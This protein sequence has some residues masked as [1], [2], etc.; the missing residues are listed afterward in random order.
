MKQY[1]REH[2]GHKFYLDTTTKPVQAVNRFSPAILLIG[3]LCGLLFFAG[4]LALLLID[5]ATIA[6]DADAISFSAVPK[7][8]AILSTTMFAYVLLVLGAGLSLTTLSLD[9]RY[10]VISYDG[11]KISVRDCPFIGKAYSF[12]EKLSNFS[13]VRLRLKFCQYGLFNKNKFIIELYHK[14]PHKIVPLYISTSQKNIRHLWR[15]YALELAL[16]PIHISDKGMVSHNVYDM[17]RP[18]V[19]VVKSWHLPQNFLSGKTHSQN[20]I[21]KQRQDK[22]MIKMPHFIYDF[23]SNLNIAVMIILSGL[24]GYALYSYSAMTTYL[25]PAI[26]W[27]F[28]ILLLILIGYAYINLVMRDVLLVHNQ[29]IIVFRKILGVSY[30]D[31][32]IPFAKLK[33]ID[34]SY[35]PTTDRY[36][37][38]LLTDKNIVTV[39]NKLSPQD[40]RWIRG[41]LVREINQ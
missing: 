14:D 28:Y 31:T 34:I 9:L 13:G 7:P 20:F 2:Y 1:F 22:K 8:Y 38:N 15:Q 4:G 5:P 39:F 29:K 37:L 35:T 17:E 18:Y 25:S 19:D 21:A 6:T 41:F 23:Y 11:E 40:L 3:L 33:G 16:P 32:L 30:Q 26:V 27:V 10:K 36:A 12:E 24:L